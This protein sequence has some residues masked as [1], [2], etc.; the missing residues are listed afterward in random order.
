[1]ESLHL[2][3]SR[4]ARVGKRGLL[5]VNK[6]IEFARPPAGKAKKKGRLLLKGK[7]T[8]PETGQ[9]ETRQ[10]AGTMEEAINR[11]L[12]AQRRT[13]IHH[14]PHALCK[15]DL[16]GW[17]P[18]ISQ[19]TIGPEMAELVV[20]SKGPEGFEPSLVHIGESP[21][22]ESKGKALMQR[23]LGKQ[24]KADMA[25]SSRSK[26]T[27]E[28]RLK[29]MEEELKRI[30]NIVQNQ[31]NILQSF[32]VEAGR[33]LAMLDADITKTKNVFTE[34]VDQVQHEHKDPKEEFETRVLKLET[35]MEKLTLNWQL[36]RDLPQKEV[37]RNFGNKGCMA[38]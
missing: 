38:A 15:T 18:Q 10:A 37:P 9:A 33:R 25:S 14:E 5:L 26:P 7:H 8:S 28:E 31:D 29:T 23:K 35:Q 22:S 4:K 32:D 2:W 13:K 34:A 17:I 3:K 20:K 36:E 6:E 24:R 27:M 12:K 16:I 30:K 1:M 21:S 19:E 11:A